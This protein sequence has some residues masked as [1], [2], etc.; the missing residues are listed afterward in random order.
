[1][2]DSNARKQLVFGKHAI[3]P[4]IVRADMQLNLA[5]IAADAR[6]IE[7]KNRARNERCIAREADERVVMQHF[8]VR[9]DKRERQR[10]LDIFTLNHRVEQRGAKVA[11][12]AQLQ[13][14]PNADEMVALR[15]LAHGLF[16]VERKRNGDFARD[17]TQTQAIAAIGRDADFKDFIVKQR[18][19]AELCAEAEL[20]HRE[21]ENEDSVIDFGESELG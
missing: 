7:R 13:K 19:R 16:E 2:A 4:E 10:Q 17:S 11:L 12:G 21:V 6:G 1:M 14:P 18:I 20:A 5:V 9:E 8:V 3:K 15:H